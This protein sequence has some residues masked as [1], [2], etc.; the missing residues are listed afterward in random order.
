MIVFNI[1]S[2]ARRTR[3]SSIERG[4]WLAKCSDEWYRVE[5]MAWNDIGAAGV[6]DQGAGWGRAIQKQGVR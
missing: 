5:H 6:M 4:F 1:I 3:K 2:G